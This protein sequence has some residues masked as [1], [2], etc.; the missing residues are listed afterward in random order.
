MI[1]HGIDPGSEK[2]AL[3]T[4][5]TE[6]FEI[7]NKKIASNDDIL[8]ELGKLRHMRF[9]TKANETVLAVE[10]MQ[11][12]GMPVGRSV[13]LTAMW[14]GRFVEAWGGEYALH[15]RT[16]I[17]TCIAGRAQAKDSDVSR[18][19]KMRFGEVGTKKNPGPLYGI[20]THLWAALA[21]A[22]YHMDGAKL[23]DW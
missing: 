13:F 17:K 2:S 15:L 6:P 22:V 3:V 12:Y 21:V 19:L 23:G 14:S 7:I 4:I 18:G 20:K 8:Y 5:Q 9:F 1:I 16:K 11:S 10:F